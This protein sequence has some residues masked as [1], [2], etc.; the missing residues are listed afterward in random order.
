M[1]RLLAERWLR[2]APGRDLAIPPR[3]HLFARRDL[4]KCRLSEGLPNW[5]HLS[6]CRD[7]YECSCA[8]LDRLVAV[9]KRAGALGA[10]LT[11]AGWGGCTVSLV[12]EVRGAAAQRACM[13]LHLWRALNRNGGAVDRWPVAAR[14][15]VSC[16]RL[17]TGCPAAP[18]VGGCRPLCAGTAQVCCALDMCAASAHAGRL[19]ER[20]ALD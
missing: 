15:A 10:R 7:L 12:H 8:E 18:D 5:A 2:V 9:A 4:H 3:L 14:H 13:V 1:E 6:A 11:G 19:R 20:M 16:V 17:T